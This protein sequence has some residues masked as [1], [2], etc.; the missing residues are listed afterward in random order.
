MFATKPK[1][2]AVTRV[3]DHADFIAEA[4]KLATVQLEKLEVDREIQRL[5]SGLSNLAAEQA[6]PIDRLTL[7]A[8]RV[9]AGEDLSGGIEAEA[10]RKE[11]GT[12]YQRQRI[13]EKAVE[14]Q[15]RRVGETRSRLS[16]ELFATVGRDVFETEAR[17]LALAS[18]AF[19]AAVERFRAAQDE[20]ERAG[21]SWNNLAELPPSRLLKI[22]LIDGADAA[23]AE[24]LFASDLGPAGNA[25]LWAVRMGALDEAEARKILGRPFKA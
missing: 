16:R 17:E 15:H 22:K 10:L 25:V 14:I 24:R 6:R 2:E 20:A 7:A 5:N 18:V 8:E 19:A 9:L 11:L 3:E 12:M 13:L 23:K 21:M 4:T 1:A